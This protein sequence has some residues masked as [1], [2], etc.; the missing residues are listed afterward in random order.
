MSVTQATR[1]QFHLRVLCF[2][3]RYEYC[4]EIAKHE[5]HWTEW[6]FFLTVVTR[7]GSRVLSLVLFHQFALHIFSGICLIVLLGGKN[8]P[9]EL[10]T[11]LLG[12]VS[13]E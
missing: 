13:R 1:L 4:G 10:F 8:I 12:F 7:C 11:V 5:I 9:P 6:V 2:H 3:G